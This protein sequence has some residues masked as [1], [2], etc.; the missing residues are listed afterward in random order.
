MIGIYADLKSLAI[1]CL[2]DNPNN[3]PLVAQVLLK[4]EEVKKSYSEEIYTTIPVT[5]KHLVTQLQVQQEQPSYLQQQEEDQYHKLKHQQL[6]V[7]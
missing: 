4:I 5:N 3:R 7:S 2:D 6:Q 1:S